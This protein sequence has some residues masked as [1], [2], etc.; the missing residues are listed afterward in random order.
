M[1]DE[2]IGKVPIIFSSTVEEATVESDRVRLQLSPE[3]AEPLELT[4]DHVIAATGYRVD[5]DRI[6]FLDASLRARIDTVKKT[7]ILSSHFES[8]VPGL[9]FVGA[10]AANSFGP[11]QR[12]AF[13]ARYAARRVASRLAA[14]RSDH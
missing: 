12:F 4:V 1:K 7:P 9:Y 11:A 8:S 13:G 2:V 6:A 14:V 10:A 3:G 5:V